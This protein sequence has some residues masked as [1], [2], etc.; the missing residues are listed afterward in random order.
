[1]SFDSVLFF[2]RGFSKAL[3]GSWLGLLFSISDAGIEERTGLLL[4]D[5]PPAFLLLPDPNPF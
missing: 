5:G 1:M 4:P 2:L 3:E